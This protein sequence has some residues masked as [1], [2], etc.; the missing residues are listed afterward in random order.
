MIPVKDLPPPTNNVRIRRALLSV[1]DKTGLVALARRLAAQGV[2]LVSSG[3]TAR[4]LREAGLAVEDVSNLTG[5][6]EILGGRVKT[7]HPAVHGGLLARRNDPD[8]LAELDAHQITPFDL[9]VV[10]LY[11]FAAAIAREGVTEAEAV[12]NID[13][14]GPGMVR[15][16]AKNFAF[17]TVVT[18]PDDYDAVAEEMAQHDGQVSMITRRRLAHTAFEHTARYDRA[19]ADF[20]VDVDETGIE[21]D[22][23]A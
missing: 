16:A 6:P 19:I 10:N 14:G 4:V 1:F 9:V 8:D 7:L 12:E 20:D 17:V 23:L 18:S 21:S 11:P 22:F 15:A 5:F 3:G 13:I 2:E